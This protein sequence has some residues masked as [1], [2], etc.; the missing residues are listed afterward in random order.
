MTTT[1]TG[2]NPSTKQRLE[3][4]K[5]ITREGGKKKKVLTGQVSEAKTSFEHLVMDSIPAADSACRQRLA[6]LQTRFKAIEAAKG[7]RKSFKDK[8]EEAE[9]QLLFE[10]IR[11]GEQIELPNVECVITQTSIE[12]IRDSVIGT[13][14]EDANRDKMDEKDREKLPPPADT[15]VLNELEAQLDGWLGELKVAADALP[16]EG[17]GEHPDE[18]APKKKRGLQAVEPAAAPVH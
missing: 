15:K 5:A 12:F 2:K 4:L 18:A 16:T 11:E 3:A 7:S 14:A 6:D 8:L 13:K 10:D 9:Y 1:K 17:Q